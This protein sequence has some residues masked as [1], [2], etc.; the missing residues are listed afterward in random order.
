MDV[1]SKV[2]S[3]PAFKGCMER[4][5]CVRAG[6]AGWELFPEFSQEWELDCPAQR[7][8]LPHSLP[9]NQICLQC[10]S[11]LHWAHGQCWRDSPSLPIPSDTRDKPGRGSSTLLSSGSP[12]NRRCV[13]SSFSHWLVE[14]WLSR[15][16][17]H[18]PGAPPGSHQTWLHS[19]VGTFG[20]RPLEVFRITSPCPGKAEEVTKLQLL[21]HLLGSS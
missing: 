10:L 15:R 14:P 16:G 12:T 5:V 20:I 7:Q 13:F 17:L 9:C 1:A 2:P 18:H 8:I 4:K 3:N 19:K 6:V 21:Q 11:V